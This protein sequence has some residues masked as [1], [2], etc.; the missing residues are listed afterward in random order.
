MR[1]LEEHA[2]AKDHAAILCPQEECGSAFSR[3][4]VFK[5]HLLRHQEDVKRHS[6]KYCKKYRGNNEFK[7]KDH[8]VQHLR[9]FH[10]IGEDEA[11]E[12][13]W[14]SYPHQD[15]TAYRHVSRFNDA[16][17][18]RTSELTTHM[19]KVHNE[20]PFPCPILGC[21]RVNGK[22]YFRRR[23]LIKH[24]QKKHVEVGDGRDA[25]EEEI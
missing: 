23:D 14:S 6:C 17:F 7:R 16:P 9:N 18:K 1:H 24:K 11:K 8:L 22:G 25:S 5:R 2:Y 20:S 15:C 21:D 3:Y 4:D 13:S 19:K 10:H 12:G